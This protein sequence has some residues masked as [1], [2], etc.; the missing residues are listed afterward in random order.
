[1][2]DRSP[3]PSLTGSFCRHVKPELIQSQA[4]DLLRLLLPTID[5]LKDEMLYLVL[6]T[7]RAILAIEK[8]ALDEESVRE[9]AEIVYDAWLE[10]SSDPV[11][12]AVTE[13]LF[14][15]IV[16]TSPRPVVHALIV[17]LSPSL[18]AT[19]AAPVTPDNEHLAA[20]AV[21]LSNSLIRT[22][23]GPLETELISTVTAAIMESLQRTDDMSVVQVSAESIQCRD[24]LIRKAGVMHLTQ[25]VRKDCDKLLQW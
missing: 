9:L 7:L 10:N 2:V 23:G 3:A 4:R 20:E 11:A 12:T 18:A 13:E 21:Q 15:V 25:V 16:S 19:I 22:R 8:N 6:E 5:D 24:P 17:A 14:E 1:M